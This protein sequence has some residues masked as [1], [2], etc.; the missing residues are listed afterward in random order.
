M[1]Y[2][3]YSDYEKAAIPLSSDGNVLQ[4]MEITYS[5]K[6]SCS[7]ALTTRVIAEAGHFVIPRLTQRPSGQTPSPPLIHLTSKKG[8]L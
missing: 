8:A 7:V 1:G 2:A 6:C 3:F 5:G 4:D